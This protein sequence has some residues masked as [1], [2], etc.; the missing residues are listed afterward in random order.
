MTR[1]EFIKYLKK[2]GYRYR[3]LGDRIIIEHPFGISL[4]PLTT[5][6]DNV[7]FNNIGH[8][9]LESLTTIPKGTRFN[10]TLDV[11]VGFLH[12]KWIS[13]W[14]GNIEGISPKKL[15]NQMISLGLFEKKR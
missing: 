8:V 1:E 10:N 6:P 15:F 11:Y 3:I 7:H 5:I 4:F 2:E 9:D 14:K 12:D 13:K